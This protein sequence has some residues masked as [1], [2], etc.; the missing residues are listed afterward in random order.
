VGFTHHKEAGRS[1]VEFP[2]HDYTKPMSVAT[3]RTRNEMPETWKKALPYLN[4]M[5]MLL[6]NAS[7][8]QMSEVGE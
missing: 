6:E 4:D 2:V 7:D 8:E 1:F 3:Y 5:E